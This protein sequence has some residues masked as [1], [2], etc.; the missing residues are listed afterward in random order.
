MSVAE[1]VGLILK[2]A[3]ELAELCQ[4]SNEELKS[5]I[6]K[7][8]DQDKF[9]SDDAWAEHEKNAKDLS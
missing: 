3:L 1:I 9:A 4:V 2:L 6:R 8:L 5:E 7:C